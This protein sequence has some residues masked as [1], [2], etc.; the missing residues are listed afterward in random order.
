MSNSQNAIDLEHLQRYTSGDLALEKE[1]YG[2]FREQAQ[3]WLKMLVVDADQEGWG[4]A[5]H[6]LKGSARGIGAHGL[7]AACEAAE[8]LV[9]SG[10][11]AR[12]V[13]IDDVRDQV[14][15]VLH[16]IDRREYKIS[17]QDLRKPSNASNS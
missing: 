1:I 5:A 4:A 15:H 17:I 16:F 11:A 12:S 7:A 14:D 2:L 8:A 13:A 6:S 10:K 9:L 3:I